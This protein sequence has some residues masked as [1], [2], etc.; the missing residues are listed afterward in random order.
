M[1]NGLFR[2]LL[3]GALVGAT[4][5]LLFAPNKGEVTRRSLKEKGNEYFEA[6][7]EKVKRDGSG[8][9]S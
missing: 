4:A 8:D 9:T 7:R 1:A 5:A 2:G 6:V 3:A